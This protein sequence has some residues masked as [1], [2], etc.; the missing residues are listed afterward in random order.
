MNLSGNFTVAGNTLLTCPG[1]SV[2]RRL[3]A[4]TRQ[5]RLGA[6]PCLG[7]NNNDQNM[8]YVNVEP[9]AITSTPA[10]PR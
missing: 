9:T 10:R 2:S 5:Q 4:R 8:K 7:A 6:E 3:R 1:N